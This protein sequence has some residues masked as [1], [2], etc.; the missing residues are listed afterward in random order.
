MNVT[1]IEFA[2][3][4]LRLATNPEV[5]GI[6]DALEQHHVVTLRLLQATAEH[7]DEIRMLK[8]ALAHGEVV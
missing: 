5:Q 1:D 8:S 2:Y 6:I 4:A 3:D 7:V